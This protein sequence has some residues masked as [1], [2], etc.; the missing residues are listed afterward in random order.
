M[1]RQRAWTTKE[2][3]THRL[4]PTIDR[5]TQ[6]LSGHA[7]LDIIYIVSA[8]WILPSAGFEESTDHVYLSK[9]QSLSF[10]T[11]NIR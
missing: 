9:S 3:W 1:N 7:A 5:L 11:E 2:R 4:I 6:V 8:I 10:I